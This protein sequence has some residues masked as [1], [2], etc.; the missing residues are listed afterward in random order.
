MSFW[1]EEGYTGEPGPEEE[2]ERARRPDGTG[3]AYLLTNVKTDVHHLYAVYNPKLKQLITLDGCGKQDTRIRV[4]DSADATKIK[5]FPVHCKSG[6]IA[7]SGDGLM[8]AVAVL[9][10]DTVDIYEL[11]TG[12]LLLSLDGG[13]REGFWGALKFMAGS[14]GLVEL[15]SIEYARGLSKRN[16]LRCWDLGFANRA[17]P[18]GEERIHSMWA[19]PV[20]AGVSAS[21]TCEDDDNDDGVEEKKWEI[22]MWKGPNH[23]TYRRDN[24]MIVASSEDERK[25]CSFEART[26]N[27]HPDT[28]ISDGKFC[29][30]IV[31]S[32]D[33]SVFAL[34]HSGSCSI[35]DASTNAVV[36]VIDMPDVPFPVTPL[37]FLQKDRLLLLR[38]NLDRHLLLCD[39][40]QPSEMLILREAGGTASDSCLVSPDE[41]YLACWPHG[42]IEYYSLEGIIEAF[43][44]KCPRKKKINM[45]LIRHLHLQ[46]RA[47]MAVV[48]D[49]TE[50]KPVEAAKSNKP[51]PAK[52]SK[53]L[54]GS[55]KATS[56]P[57]STAVVKAVVERNILDNPLFWERVCKV[58]DDVFRYVMTFI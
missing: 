9:K 41:K 5:E 19:S 43:K 28:A 29:A 50:K 34:S 15:R 11:S 6:Y 51:A 1:W 24:N 30:K 37:A 48:A 31:F 44:N 45:L 33:H 16:V 22:E 14:N 25:V 13:R 26:G 20:S 3:L 10:E 7:V 8:V 39:W 56:A 12:D 23:F 47:V 17:D 4:W 21:S 52:N 38:I 36:S 54:R 40:R 35:R 58:D 46:K 27:C 55:G 53:S 18:T 42:F 57:K 2:K 49:S 32:S